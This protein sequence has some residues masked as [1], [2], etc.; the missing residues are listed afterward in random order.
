MLTGAI[1]QGEG[2]GGQHRTFTL[3]VNA[4]RTTHT[5]LKYAGSER[6]N[7]QGRQDEME[8]KANSIQDTKP[9]QLAAAAMDHR[10]D[11][12]G[13]KGGKARVRQQVAANHTVI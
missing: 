7:F 5:P 9:V 10:S 13:R 4:D 12:R 3:G 8:V 1:D 11:I 6:V 2:G